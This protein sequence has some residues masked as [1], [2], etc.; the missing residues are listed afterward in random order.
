MAGISDMKKLEPDLLDMNLEEGKI[1]CN[2]E[3]ILKVKKYTQRSPQIERA[4]FWAVHWMLK[5]SKHFQ[6]IKEGNIQNIKSN[7][8]NLFGIAGMERMEYAFPDM[9]QICK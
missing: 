9:L 2:D 3:E 8:M 6:N 1:K 7:L 5:N 4:H